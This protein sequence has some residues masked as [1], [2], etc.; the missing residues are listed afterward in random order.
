MVMG[1]TETFETEASQDISDSQE[2]DAKSP[3]ELLEGTIHDKTL[4]GVC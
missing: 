2:G 4:P 3:L 1:K